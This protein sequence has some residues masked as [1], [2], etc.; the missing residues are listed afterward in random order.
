MPL[1]LWVVGVDEVVAPVMGTA[2][3]GGGS[4]GDG[5]IG[6]GLAG[7]GDGGGKLRRGRSVI[8]IVGLARGAPLKG[9][10]V[11]AVP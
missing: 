6:G 7:G 4:A 11:E 9:R 3:G 10:R 5:E 8:V 1:P 2:S